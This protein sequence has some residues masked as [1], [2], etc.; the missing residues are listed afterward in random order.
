MI[1]SWLFT[2]AGLYQM[3]DWALKKH[4]NYVK[5]DPSIKQKKK[6]ILPYIL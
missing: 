5:A 4:R 6:A 3:A 2:A 1:S